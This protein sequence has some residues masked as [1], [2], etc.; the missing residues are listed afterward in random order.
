M[1][2]SGQFKAGENWRG[3]ANGRPKGT[4]KDI[5]IKLNYDMVQ[6][7]APIIEKVLMDLAIEARDGKDQA[8]KKWYVREMKEIIYGKPKTEIEI[9]DM[10]ERPDLSGATNDEIAKIYESLSAIM[11]REGQ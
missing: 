1:G 6:A 11:N 4:G 2:H 5:R 10:R 7:H 9:G 3:N 8:L